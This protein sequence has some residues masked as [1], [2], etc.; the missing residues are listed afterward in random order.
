LTAHFT[1]N[2]LMFCMDFFINHMFKGECMIK[3]PSINRNYTLYK[4]IQ[5]FL[6]DSNGHDCYF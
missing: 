3:W 5:F 1:L 2:F 6:N 4:S